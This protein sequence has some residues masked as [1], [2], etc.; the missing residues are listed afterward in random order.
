[1]FTQLLFIQVITGCL[2]NSFSVVFLTK[3]VISSTIPSSNADITG[4]PRGL[5]EK[6]L[7]NMQNDLNLL[8]D[9]YHL[10]LF[11]KLDC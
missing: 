1:M 2:E 7:L 8:I 10:K 11:I 5:N 3:G 4:F 9:I 6:H